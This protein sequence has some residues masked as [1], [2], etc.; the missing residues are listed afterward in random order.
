MHVGC[1]FKNYYNLPVNEVEGVYWFYFVRPLICPYVDQ[2]VS[3][4]YLPQYKP[5]PFHIYTSYQP[6]SGGVSHAFFLI[7][8]IRIFADFF[9]FHDLA[10][11]VLASSGC[12]MYE[13]FYLSYFISVMEIAPRQRVCCL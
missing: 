5:D 10:H 12:E 6:T 4:L 2:I 3:T 7:K 1:V 13:G 8:K 9:L 11:Y